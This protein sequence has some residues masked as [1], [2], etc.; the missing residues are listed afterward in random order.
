MVKRSRPLG[1]SGTSRNERK[2]G[3]PENP[4]HLDDLRRARPDKASGATRSQRNGHSFSGSRSGSG[5]PKVPALGQSKLVG[6]GRQCSINA[7]PPLIV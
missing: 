7:S 1:A 3:A 4:S 6:V 2:G 5:M